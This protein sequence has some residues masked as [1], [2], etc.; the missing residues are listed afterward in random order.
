M[1]MAKTTQHIGIIDCART[2]THINII[3]I[4]IIITYYYGGS[5]KKK[6]EIHNIH[7]IKSQKII[8]APYFCEL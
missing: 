3:F 2:H 7:C 8:C 5:R 4:L 1:I 6:R